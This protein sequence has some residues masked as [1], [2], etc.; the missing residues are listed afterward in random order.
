MDVIGSSVQDVGIREDAPV[1]AG[2]LRKLKDLDANRIA[3]TDGVVMHKAVLALLTIV[4]D[5]ESRVA[6]LEA[7]A[8][9]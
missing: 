8:D 2:V 7:E 9:H 6:A 3:S 4:S 1:T 5:L